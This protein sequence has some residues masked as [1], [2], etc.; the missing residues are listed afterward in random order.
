MAL[1]DIAVGINA[2]QTAGAE[3]QAV[4]V[5]GGALVS[6]ELERPI[7]LSELN[8]SF[9]IFD[10]HPHHHPRDRDRDGIP[11]RWDPNPYR[12]NRPR[13]FPYYGDR[14]CRW[15]ERPDFYVNGYPR[16]YR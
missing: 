15:G 14:P 7:Q 6:S 2:R 10:R 8:L 11:D 1:Q 12:P 13:P 5:S 3:P 4:R 9:G 16:C